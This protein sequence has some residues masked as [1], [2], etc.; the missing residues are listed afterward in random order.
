M[1]LGFYTQ[2]LRREKAIEKCHQYLE[3]KYFHYKIVN[4]SKSSAKHEG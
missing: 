3:R 4:T 1:T 2:T